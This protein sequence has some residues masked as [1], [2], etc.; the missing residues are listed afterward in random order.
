MNKGGAIAFSKAADR[1]KG[2]PREGRGGKRAVPFFIAGAN[3]SC[4]KRERQREV[5]HTLAETERDHRRRRRERS[6]AEHPKKGGEGVERERTAL[7]ARRNQHGDG[8]EGDGGWS[9]RQTPKR[10]Q[11]WGAPPARAG[12]A[13][14]GGGVGNAQAAAARDGALHARS[15]CTHLLRGRGIDGTSSTYR[16]HA[17]DGGGGQRGFIGRSGRPRAALECRGRFIDECCDV[18]V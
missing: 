8:G 12:R 6:V 2:E 16:G 13:C 14:V 9:A 10:R 11:E 1:G 18:R 3:S 17:A 4:G 5:N 7:A 15:T